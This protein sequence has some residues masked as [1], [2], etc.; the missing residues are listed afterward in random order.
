[1]GKVTN[2]L[3]M[4]MLLQSR[5]LMTV[6]EI[7]NELD[8]TPRMVKNYKEDLEDAYIYIGSIL[9]RHGGYYL[10][11]HMS[12]RGVAITTEELD[13]LKKAG[14]VIRNGNYH[15]RTDFDTLTSKILNEKNDFRETCYYS[16]GIAPV[17]TE[18]E[19]QVWKDINQSIEKKKKIKIKY[20][21]IGKKQQNIQ[22]RIIHPYG[23]CDH[24][25]AAYF[26]GYC[27]LRKKA[28]TFKLC[29]I[30][31][32]EILKE[33]FVI[34]PRLDFKETFRNSFGIYNDAPI[35]LNLKIHY[36]MS[37]IV[38]EKIYST[39]QKIEDAEDQSILFEAKMGGYT[40]IKAWVM[41]MGSLVEVIKPL[42]LK[43]DIK[44]EMRKVLELYNKED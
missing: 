26:Y 37:Q 34:S 24:K 13:A 5:G 6:G 8:V 42:K 14:K 23:L 17:A 9:G 20:A 1:M 40:E 12:L 7:A 18:N 3:K 25:G 21:S 16:K 28:R 4:Y 19:Q 31:S 41:G 44:N 43:E 36:P 35:D 10:E 29:R 2:A 30:I 33:V 11:N 39:N 27:E 15:Y 22:E 38:K 32:H